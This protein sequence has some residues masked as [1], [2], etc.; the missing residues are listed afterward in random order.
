MNASSILQTITSRDKL[1]FVQNQ[2]EV[3]G[4]MRVALWWKKSP[5]FDGGFWFPDPTS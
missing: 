4:I 2:K 5:S 3:T 1:T